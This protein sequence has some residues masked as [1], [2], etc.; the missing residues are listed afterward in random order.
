MQLYGDTAAFHALLQQPVEHL[1]H[2]L[3]RRR[4]LLGQAGGTYRALDLGAARQELDSPQPGQ[5]VLS[6][7]PAVGGLDPAAEADRGGGDHDVRRLVDDLLGRR[8]QL[9][10]VGELHDAQGGGMHDGGSA[11]LEQCA[12]LVGPA[13]GGHPHGEAREGAV[14]R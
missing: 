3:G 10:V 1:G 11:P 12:Q 8:E 2:G 7:A 9:A 14:V 13:R 5:Q 6:E 4:P